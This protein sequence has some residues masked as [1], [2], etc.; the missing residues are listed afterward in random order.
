[1]RAELERVKAVA[2]AAKV[3]E[4]IGN[5]RQLIE[6]EAESTVG[7][8]KLLRTERQERIAEL[9]NQINENTTGRLD[10]IRQVNNNTQLLKAHDK[11]LTT[12]GEEI[13]LIKTQLGEGVTIELLRDGQAPQAVTKQLGETFRLII[14][15]A[16]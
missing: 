10:L 11:L 7:Q 12:V 14:E 15:D 9:V 6:L 13:Q 4:K 5:L 3:D 8:I 16:Q 1:M 2:E